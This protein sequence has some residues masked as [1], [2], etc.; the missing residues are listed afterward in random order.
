MGLDK[1]KLDRIL[2]NCQC[3]KTIIIIDSWLVCICQ[4]MGALGKLLSN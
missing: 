4:V 3:Y 2:V 1:L